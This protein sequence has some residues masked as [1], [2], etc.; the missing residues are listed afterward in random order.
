MGI[1]QVVVGQHGDA[2]ITSC[3]PRMPHRLGWLGAHGR[4]PDQ[5]LSVEA[6]FVGLLISLRIL[7]AVVRR[8]PRRS[9]WCFDAPAAS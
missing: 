5:A 7:E 6:E 1:A 3:L 2:A 4:F 8:H 9:K